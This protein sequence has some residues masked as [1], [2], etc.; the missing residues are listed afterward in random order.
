[1]NQEQEYADE[2]PRSTWKWWAT[3]QLT[4][5]VVGCGLAVG[6]ARGVDAVT[7][8]G[9]VQYALARERVLDLVPVRTEVREVSELELGDIVAQVS[10][11]HGLDPIV[12]ETL[13]ELESGGGKFRYRFEPGLY[14][15]LRRSSKY[16]GRSDDEVRMMAS[17][18]S[19]FHILGAS[20]EHFCGLKWHQLHTTPTAAQCAG[21]IL[22]KLFAEEKATR[23]PGERLRR[24][25]RKW[26][27]SGE[28]AERYAD[29]A[30][31]VVAKKLYKRVAAG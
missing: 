11:A 6:V 17:S 21:T 13:V 12:M 14:A 2:R 28:I 25:F 20:G 24:V 3:K 5:L 10:K 30:M 31:A 9:Q 23:E 16:K 22:G 18:H 8:W 1:M 27:G 4:R 7:T 26:N 15:A 19:E 29:K